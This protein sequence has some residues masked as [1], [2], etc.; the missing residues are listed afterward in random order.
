MK[1]ILTTIIACCCVA[2]ALLHAQSVTVT[3]TGRDTQNHYVPLSRVEARNLTKGWQETLIWPDTVLV[4][5]VSDDDG[6]ETYGQTQNFASLR[7]SQNNPNPFD[8]TT[9][10]TLQVAEP[11]EVDVVVTDITGRVVETWCT[12]SLQPGTYEICVT[13]ASAGLY[14]LT[15]RQNGRTATVKMMNRGNGRNDAITV[16]PHVE[17]GHAPSL[18]RVSGHSSLRQNEKAHRSAT[19]NPFDLGDQMEY[20]GFAVLN[21]A[22][23]ESNHVTGAQ[24]ASGTVIFTFVNAQPCAD[25]PTVTDID[26]NV[27]NTVQI[28]SQCWMKENL[29]TTRYEDG[30][31]IPAGTYFSSTEPYYY[32]NNSTSIPLAERG[33]LYNWPAVMHGRA[34]SN[35]VPSGVQ[36]ICPEGWHVPS[37]AEW[38]VLT[39]YVSS[40]PEYVCGGNPDYIAKALASKL[41]WNS[42]SGAC[43][44]GDQS[45]EP[46][47]ATGFAAVPAGSYL[48]YGYNDEGLYANFWSATEFEDYPGIARYLGMDYD[49]PEASHAVGTMSHRFAVRCLR[50]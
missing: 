44:P 31:S 3:F 36:G 48:S 28:G 19:D 20:V 30:D 25:F 21:G 22:E 24:L 41:W 39:S 5:T 26:G 38:V 9:F 14:F 33:Y 16:S 49:T 1:R 46:N 7:L 11:G 35:T 4:M 42:Y 17:T 12:A 45:V 37:D 18:R 27:Y 13:L 15:A 10:V 40:Q 47:N 43:Y 29:R 50:N 6:I 34:A 23:Q 8:G 2:T 32:D